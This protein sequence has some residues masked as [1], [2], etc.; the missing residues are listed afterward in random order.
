M[1]YEKR[2]ANL[3]SQMQAK[4][5]DSLLVSNI[6]N[7]Y[8]LSGFTGSSAALLI[9][10]DSCRILVDPRYT[11]QAREQC[12]SAEV[13]EFT[14]K[15]IMSAAGG[16]VAELA[17]RTLGFEAGH[18]TVGAYRELRKQAGRSTGLRATENLVESLRQ[19]K[20]AD[21]IKAIR[22]AAQ[23][24]DAAFDAV[25]LEIRPGMTERET[26]TLIEFTLRRMGADREAFPAIAA[27]GPNAARPHA[28]PTDTVLQRGQML[29]LDFGGRYQGYCSDL[30]R[31]VSLGEPSDRLR[32]IYEVVLEAQ[33]AA[34]DAV[35]P[36][37]S[38][39]DIDAVARDV[40][41]RRGY[42]PNFGH[43]LGHMIGIAVHDGAAFSATSKVVLQPGMTATVE[44]GI[45]IEGWGGVRIEDDILVTEHGV[46]V[47]T[48]ATKDLLSI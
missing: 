19:V 36:G 43:G 18:L 44:P 45:Y 40:I 28:S 17:P 37:V 15:T 12:P 27:T 1:V 39:A 11:L 14:S 26:A 29:K 8:Y 25:L 33:R 30:T 3:R 24:A 16:L 35:R 48:G 6:E 23:I 31:T 20:D 7:V 13:V 9:T 10:G 41:T 34:I 2:L 47:L 38:G 21:E 46:E 42:G 4:K 22:T 5:L 32:E